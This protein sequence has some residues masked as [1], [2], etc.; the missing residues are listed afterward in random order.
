MKV[1]EIKEALSNY[2]DDDEL[3]ALWW[4]NDEFEDVDPEK[5]PEVAQ[6]AMEGKMFESIAQQGAE[7]IQEI[8]D[9]I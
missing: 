8:A 3:I 7:A 4:G 9:E 1:S 5:W 2:E 6:S